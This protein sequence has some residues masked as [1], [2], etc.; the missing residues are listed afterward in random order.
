[1]LYGYGEEAVAPPIDF[2]IF[3]LE[4]PISPNLREFGA[5]TEYITNLEV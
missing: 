1:M 3:L 4:L 5:F 2:A